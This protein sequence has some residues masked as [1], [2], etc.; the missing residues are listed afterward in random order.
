MRLKKGGW[1]HS[2]DEKVYNTAGI[3]FGI[4]FISS[5]RQQGPTGWLRGRFGTRSKSLNHYVPRIL[6]RIQQNLYDDAY[7]GLLFTNL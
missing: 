7:I 5:G 3:K 6:I 2:L 4:D 1:A